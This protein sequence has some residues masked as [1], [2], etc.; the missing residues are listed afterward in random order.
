M[1]R[2]LIAAPLLTLAPAQA[3]ADPPFFATASISAEVITE[4]DPTALRS[5]T[6]TG[7]GERVIIDYRVF[8]WVTVEAYLFEAQIGG[9]VI[10]EP[11]RAAG[12][13]PGAARWENRASAYWRREEAGRSS[14]RCRR[15]A[16]RTARGAP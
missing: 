12:L 4:A 15:K 6:Y 14:E 16:D 10:E 5:V 1:R 11:R 13:R 8:D 3:A 7:R 2:L 9:S